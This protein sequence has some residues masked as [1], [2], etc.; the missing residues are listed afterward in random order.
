MGGSPVMTRCS[1]RWGTAGLEAPNGAQA[2]PASGA[3]LPVAR[4]DAALL[5]RCCHQLCPIK[6]RT[7]MN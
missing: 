6:V 1:S 7:S 5:V 4:H 2:G 3:S